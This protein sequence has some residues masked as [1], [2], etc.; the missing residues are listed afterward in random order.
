MREVC[1]CTA[2]LKITD[3]EQWSVEALLEVFA[4]WRESHIHE[5]PAAEPAEPPTF[6]ESGSSHERLGD[7]FP[8]Q[9]RATIGFQRNEV[10]MRGRALIGFQRNEVR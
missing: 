4:N 2:E 5:M 9:D 10:P 1:S 6:V 3:I 8:M 7:E